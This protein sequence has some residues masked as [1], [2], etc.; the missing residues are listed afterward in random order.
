[1]NRNHSVLS[2]REAFPVLEDGTNSPAFQ[3]LLAEYGQAC[4]E[5]N[6]RLSKRK[7]PLVARL[8]LGGESG[9]VRRRGVSARGGRPR[10]N[11]VDT[12]REWQG[13]LDQPWFP[14]L[15][16]DKERIS[17]LK[18]ET[19]GVDVGKGP[20]EEGGE[21]GGVPEGSCPGCMAPPVGHGGRPL[22][23]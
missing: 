16:E 13:R 21:G 17:G 14:C 1:M 20:L 6:A 12:A 10:K 5:L 18:E 8:P 2:R 11:S 15:P 19:E 22:L 9:G 4:E 7:S 23:S 3:R